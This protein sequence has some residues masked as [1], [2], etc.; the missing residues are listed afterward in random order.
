MCYVVNWFVVYFRPQCSIQSYWS[1]DLFRWIISTVLGQ[2]T[3]VARSQRFSPLFVNLTCALSGRGFKL[4]KI[5]LHTFLFAIETEKPPRSI[6]YW[7]NF[8][9]LKVWEEISFVFSNNIKNTRRK[10]RGSVIHGHLVCLIFDLSVWFN[11]IDHGI[12]FNE[13]YRRSLDRRPQLPG[14]K[15]TGTCLLV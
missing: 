2:A 6:V 15:D 14:L 1:W 3:S 5:F 11:P 12:C 4:G 9:S 7:K 8:A 13:W 10:D